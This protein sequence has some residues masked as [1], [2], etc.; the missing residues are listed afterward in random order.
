MSETDSFDFVFTNNNHVMSA[1]ETM[2]SEI[3]AQATPDAV[4]SGILYRQPASSL[5]VVDG[6]EDSSAITQDEWQSLYGDLISSSLQDSVG[7]S[8]SDVSAR[9][10]AHRQGG[11]V[12]IFVAEC[13]YHVI[14]NWAWVALDRQEGAGGAAAFPFREARQLFEGRHAVFASAMLA[15]P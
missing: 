14:R 11:N 7:P 13:A 9:A 15:R 12:P 3:L 8:V 6:G 1:R 4:P 5:P 2:L 10:E